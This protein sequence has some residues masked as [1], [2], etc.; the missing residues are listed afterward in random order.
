MSPARVAMED[1]CV[2]LGSCAAA[3]GRFG[4]FA[5]AVTIIASLWDHVQRQL[6]ND[7]IGGSLALATASF[8]TNLV[9]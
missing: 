1:A 5:R 7:F 2:A 6:S 8:V 3:F 4:V 9:W